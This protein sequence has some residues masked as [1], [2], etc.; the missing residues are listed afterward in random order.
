MD[1]NFY[2]PKFGKAFRRTDDFATQMRGVDFYLDMHGKQVAFDEKAKEANYGGP[3]GFEMTL[4]KNGEERE[5]WFGG[6]W[7][8]AEII[9]TITPKAATKYPKDPDAIG[10]AEVFWTSKARLKAW[11]ESRGRTMEQLME[12]ARV[13][14]RDVEDGGSMEFKRRYPHGDFWLTLST[15]LD[16]RPVNLVIPR[17][18]L[19]SLSAKKFSV[20]KNF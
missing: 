5:G 9:A 14:R 16:E 15:W 7:A 13:L 20:D 6:S 3:V 8:Q 1:R 12:D 2:V 10:S 4:V 17:A 11:V 19:E 18:T